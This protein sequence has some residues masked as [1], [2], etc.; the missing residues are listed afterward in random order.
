MHIRLRTRRTHIR[1]RLLTLLTRLR[2]RWRRHRIPGLMRE[3][4]TLNGTRSSGIVI[5]NDSCI[6][7]DVIRTR[8]FRLDINAAIFGRCRE[9]TNDMV[10]LAPLRSSPKPPRRHTPLFCRRIRISKTKRSIAAAASISEDAARHQQRPQHAVIVLDKVREEHRLARDL[11]EKAPRLGTTKRLC[12]SRYFDISSTI[13]STNI[14]RVKLVNFFLTKKSSAAVQRTKYPLPPALMSAAIPTKNRGAELSAPHL[15]HIALPR[16][17]TPTRG[18]TPPTIGVLYVYCT[19]TGL[20]LCHRRLG[21]ILTATQLLQHS[22]ALILTL[23]LLEGLLDVL[24]LL[25]RHDNHIVLF[26]F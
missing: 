22:R 20:T 10:S 1:L 5:L 13:I 3:S 25:Y 23:E 17:G 8:R 11:H 24:A 18:T 15:R 9:Y 21:E 16:A 2:R 4:I 7:R 19:L 12:V 26:L 14:I 6:R